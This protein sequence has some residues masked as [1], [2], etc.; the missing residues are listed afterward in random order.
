MIEI[1]N[2]SKSFGDKQVLNDISMTFLPGKC[3]MVIGTSG[4][5][6][7]VLMKL[8]VGLE[9]PDT[10][11][12]LFD[13]QDFTNMD[14]G[15]KIDVRRQIGMLFQSSALFDSLSVED[16]VGF[17][18]KMFSK[19]SKEEQ[20]ERINFCLKHVKLENQNKKF[21]SE[22]SGG[23]KKRVGI[24]RAIALNPKYLFCDEP[25]SG[26]DP[27]T[28]RIIDNLIQEITEEFKTTTIINSHDMKSVYDIGDNILYINKGNKWWEGSREEIK[29]NSNIELQEFV[30]ASF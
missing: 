30:A 19:M 15:T 11:Q 14:Y 25:N 29:V 2:I 4:S 3:N 16:N 17:P 18:L 10:G 6:K 7:S 27:L 1:K 24:A 22:L 13:G 23:M 9:M 12:I 20:M 21:P 8:M 26:L 5:G 28:S